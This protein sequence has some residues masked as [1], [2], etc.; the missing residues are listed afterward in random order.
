MHLSRANGANTT[1]IRDWFAIFCLPAIAKIKPENRYNAN[2]AGIAKGKG[3][4]G[5]VLG[6]TRRKVVL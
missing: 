2:E 5:I 1:I 4:N 3:K 6:P